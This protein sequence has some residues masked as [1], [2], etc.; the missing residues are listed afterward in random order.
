MNGLLKQI[1]RSAQRLKI[2]RRTSL[3]YTPA[4]GCQSEFDMDSYLRTSLSLAYLRYWRK[5]KCI[6]QRAQH[7]IY[8][9]RENIHHS[10]RHVR[11]P[12]MP[13]PPAVGYRILN[14]SL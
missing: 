4:L 14:L 8:R 1:R 6:G 9:T 3:I 13:R 12:Q 5:T 11:D 7:T 2:E 10:T